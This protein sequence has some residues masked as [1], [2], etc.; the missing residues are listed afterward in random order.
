MVLF[1]LDM[2]QTYADGVTCII[3]MR[4]YFVLSTPSFATSSF[5]CNS[6]VIYIR[7]EVLFLCCCSVCLENLENLACFT[8]LD[9][10]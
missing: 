4:K 7:Q 8:S 9:I 5:F 3:S 6:C 1:C 2:W 10:V